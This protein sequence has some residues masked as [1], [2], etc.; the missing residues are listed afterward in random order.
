MIIV[1]TYFLWKSDTTF[2]ALMH[3]SIKKAFKARWDFKIMAS[4]VQRFFFPYFTVEP[5]VL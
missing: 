1:S 3:L 4:Y 5:I 2:S